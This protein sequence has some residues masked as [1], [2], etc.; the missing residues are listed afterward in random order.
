MGREEGIRVEDL[1]ESDLFSF[2]EFLRRKLRSK[3]EEI[4]DGIRE[5]AGAICEYWPL[6]IIALSLVPLAIG[7]IF[8]I[9]IL[10]CI[11]PVMILIS[12]G[13]ASYGVLHDEYARELN[14]IKRKAREQGDKRRAKIEF[15]KYT[16]V[17]N[18]EEESTE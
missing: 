4:K 2:N 12:L 17:Q 18:R 7:L 14:K 13:G 11:C 6:S 15:L 9:T 16:R 1:E 8:N 3:W 5:L 10:I